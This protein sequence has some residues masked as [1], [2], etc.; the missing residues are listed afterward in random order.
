MSSRLIE[1]SNAKHPE[2]TLNFI[3]SLAPWALPPNGK[4]GKPVRIKYVAIVRCLSLY[5][6]PPSACLARSF[7]C[8]KY[9]NLTSYNSR[10]GMSA[11]LDKH[12]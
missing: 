7:L 6:H 11:S 3:R 8:S 2:V 1:V 5:L 10:R 4:S 12:Q 9:A